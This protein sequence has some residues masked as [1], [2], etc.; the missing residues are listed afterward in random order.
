MPPVTASAEREI[1]APADRLYRIIADYER[2]H[3]H[4]LPPQVTDLIV[5]EGGVGAGTIIRFNV[6]L[7]GS[8]RTNRARIEEPEPGRVLV[9]QDLESDLATTFT[10]TPAGTGARVRIE[11]AWTPSGLRGFIEKLMAPPMLRRVY[12]AEL[13]LLE[14]YAQEQVH[15]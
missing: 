10:V 15:A 13:A 11:T 2:H 4:I 7:A 12:L 8:T 6:T 5:E 1:A 14:R 3:P 9:E